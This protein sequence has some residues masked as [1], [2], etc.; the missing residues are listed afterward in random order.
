MSCFI[1]STEH[2]NELIHI[3]QRCRIESNRFNDAL[4]LLTANH[5]SY[6]ERYNEAMPPEKELLILARQVS[7]M[8]KKPREFSI[9]ELL[10]LLG[11][12]EYQ[13]CEHKG[14]YTSK[15]YLKCQ[16]YKDMLIRTLPEWG[17]VWAYN[18]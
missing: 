8:R 18:G 2:I 9:V 14:W 5:L 15:A 11:C 12:Y 4:L 7:E 13:S 16:E 3:P 1:L 10:S 17:N 6:S